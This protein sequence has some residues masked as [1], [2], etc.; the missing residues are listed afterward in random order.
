MAGHKVLVRRV[1]LANPK[2]LREAA[3]QLRDEHKAGAVVLAAVADGKV[4]LVVAAQKDLAGKDGRF[5]AGKLVG[6]LATQLGGKGG[7]R[8][9]IAQAGGNKPE[10]LDEVL[11]Q[12]FALMQ[13]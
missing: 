3:E 5:H 1:D 9:D 4:A 10:Q 12:T 7:G 6:A 2:A 8:P 13:G 11:A